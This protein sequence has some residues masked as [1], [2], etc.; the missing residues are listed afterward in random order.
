MNNLESL[1]TFI[2]RVSL[3]A[4]RQE[5]NLICQ[6]YSGCDW[7][8]GGGDEAL[9]YLEGVEDSLQQSLDS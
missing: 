9:A 7:C 6:N 4:V 5:I 8:C 1:L 2:L 3:G